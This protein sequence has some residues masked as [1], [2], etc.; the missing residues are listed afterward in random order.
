[1]KKLTLPND[2]FARFKA[3]LIEK[4]LTKR[5]QKDWHSSLIGRKLYFTILSSKELP[6]RH[7]DTQKSAS[8]S[9]LL[10]TNSSLNM[11]V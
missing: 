4:L 3:E 9:P 11:G 1:M 10:G 6:G 8:E 2:G 5:T 7:F